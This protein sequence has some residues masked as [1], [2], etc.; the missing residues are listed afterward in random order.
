VPAEDHSQKNV[1]R[2]GDTTGGRSFDELARELARGSVS[3]GQALKLACTALLSG[4]LGSFFALP[5]VASAQQ[6]VGGGSGGS[7]GKHHSRHHLHHNPGHHQGRAGSPLTTTP[8]PECPPQTT[9]P[10][11]PPPPTPSTCCPPGSVTTTSQG[12][13]QCAALICPSTGQQF[14]CGHPTSSEPCECVVT[15]TGEGFCA[16]HPFTFVDCSSN[17]DCGLG[18]CVITC[19]GA[20]ACV[21]PC[22]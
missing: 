14:P 9:C 12:E 18:R 1:V 7:G 8:C 6:S 2:P 22:I 3:R 19:D 4:A 10:E 11:C 13:C 15:V 17:A 5:R 16:Q 21:G 20:R